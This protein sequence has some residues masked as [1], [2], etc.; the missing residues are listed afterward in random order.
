MVLLRGR[1]PPIIGCVLAIYISLCLSFAKDVASLGPRDTSIFHRDR[2]GFRNRKGQIMEGDINHIIG[3]ITKIVGGS[4][5]Q[6][7][8]IDSTENKPNG[9]TQNKTEESSDELKETN[10]EETDDS[11]GPTENILPEVSKE[12]NQEEEEEIDVL[13]SVVSEQNE[14]VSQVIRNLISSR[15]M[16]W[17]RGSRMSEEDFELR[18]IISDS[19]NEYVERLLNSRSRRRKKRPHPLKVLHQVAPKIPA[20]QH[21]PDFMLRIRSARADLDS[22]IA[23]CAIGAVAS[24]TE[25]YDKIIQKSH[26][27]DDD[28]TEPLAAATEIISDRRFEQLVECLLC[29]VNVKM[30]LA[31]ASLLENKRTAELGDKIENDVSNLDGEQTQE[32]VQVD[33]V[34]DEHVEVSNDK[35]SGSKGANGLINEDIMVADACR[36]AWGMS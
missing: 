24:V 23:A 30:R 12:I 22:G 9:D 2:I 36:A 11:L 17:G 20:I 16:S 6:G 28:N 35:E 19:A 1:N 21:S 26:H 14:Q 3:N 15:T 10:G 8:T 7:E 31:E 18:S 5:E 27:S 4:M 33:G 13:A 25:L 32:G 34:D 29:G